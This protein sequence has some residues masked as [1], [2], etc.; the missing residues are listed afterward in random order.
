M[1]QVLKMALILVWF[2]V[3]VTGTE[4][5]DTT[6]CFCLK[7]L[8]DGLNNPVHME[9]TTLNGKDIFLIAE[10]R[11]IIHSLNPR[12]GTLQTYIDLRSE[13]VSSPDLFD[14]RGLLGFA[15]HPN[16]KTNKKLYTYT[17]RGVGGKDYVAISVVTGQDLAEEQLMMLIEQPGT[18][19]N[20]GQV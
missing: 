10:Q 18:R 16:F 12:D 20:G 15:L 9:A 17:I 7:S 5:T 3:S 14:E 6:E 8:K 4:D 11:G 1:V 2:P 13:I 19:R